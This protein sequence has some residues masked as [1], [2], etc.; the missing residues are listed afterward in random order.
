MKRWIWLAGALLVAALAFPVK[1]TCGATNYACATAPD[2]QGKIAYYYEIEPLAARMLDTLLQTNTRIA[3][4]SGHD[5]V[6]VRQ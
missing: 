3:Y 2:E 4:T 5:H 6:S 1:T